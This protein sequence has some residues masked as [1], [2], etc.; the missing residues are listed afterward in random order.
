MSFAAL[1][2][3]AMVAG[4]TAC[5]GGGGGATSSGAGSSSGG[6]PGAAG[7]AASIPASARSRTVTDVATGQGVPLGSL[8][9]TDRA[10]LVWFWAPH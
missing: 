7:G 4:A 10:L 8:L 2:A 9:P 5:G 6:A 1:L 3:V